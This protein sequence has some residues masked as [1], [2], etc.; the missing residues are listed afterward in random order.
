MFPER[1][2]IAMTSSRFFSKLALGALLGAALAGCG[3]SDKSGVEAY[4][5]GDYATAT[6]KFQKSGSAKGEYY[7]GLMA[8]NGQGRP[9][10]LA[11]A[12]RLLKKSADRGYPEAQFNLGTLYAKGVGVPLDK[13]QALQWYQKAAEQGSTRAQFNL[14]L[15]YLAGDGV[16]PDKKT[17][18]SWI[19]KAA[20]KDDQRAKQALKMLGQ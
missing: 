9:Q 10:D 7:L 3:F 1:N 15:M 11:E 2:D 6:Q 16:R 4:T 14:G 20:E 19:K 12:V 17:A 8:L 5:K 13:Q 18:V